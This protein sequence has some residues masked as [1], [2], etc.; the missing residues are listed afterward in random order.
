MTAD[1]LTEWKQLS[2]K[3]LEEDQVCDKRCRGVTRAMSLE[4]YGSLEALGALSN[5]RDLD[6]I[7][8]PSAISCQPK[9]FINLLEDLNETRLADLQKINRYS[10]DYLRSL[11]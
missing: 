9:Y 8:C 4:E 1:L 7:K 3:E 2:D 6:Q 11:N 5:I 10:I